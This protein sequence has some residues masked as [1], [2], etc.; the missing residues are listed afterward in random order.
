MTDIMTFEVVERHIARC[1]RNRLMAKSGVNL[2]ALKDFIRRRKDGYW[3]SPLLNMSG[4]RNDYLTT[5]N[6]IEA[7][8]VF[9]ETCG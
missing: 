1:L 5:Y 3:A 8:E 6:A 7:N 2:E 4:K 9:R